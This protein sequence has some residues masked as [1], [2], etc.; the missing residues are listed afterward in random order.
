MSKDSDL[1]T[2]FACEWRNLEAFTERI[3][4]H[5]ET[6]SERQSIAGK[7]RM[8]LIPGNSSLRTF[9]AAQLLLAAL[10]LTGCGAVFVGFISNPQLPPSSTTGKIV[11]VVLGSVDD[12]QRNP[13]TITTVT[14]VNA[15]LESTLN[16]CGDQRARLPI[17][18]VV[19]VDFTREISCFLL[20]NV[21]VL[22]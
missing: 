16:F 1:M 21:F 6:A 17:D 18:E 3:A 2:T 7:S 9:F 10:S 5:F 12:P 4:S 13:L 22:N 20:V 11:A 8:N 15:G 14:L 19:R